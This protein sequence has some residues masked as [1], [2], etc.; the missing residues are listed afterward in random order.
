MAIMATDTVKKNKVALAIC[1]SL[2]S[3][4]SVAAEWQ[5]T[6]SIFVDE[7]YTDNVR[8]TRNDEKSSLVSQVGL[9]IESSYL[10]R[11]VQFDFKSAS[12]YAFYSHDHDIDDDYQDV[13]SNITAKLGESGFALIGN[14][15]IDNQSSDGSRNALADL[16]SGDTVQV[17]TYSSGIAY[18][19]SNS[20]FDFNSNLIYSTTNTEDKI[21]EQ[22][23]YSATVQSQNGG[24]ADYVFWDLQSGYQERKNR[25][26]SSRQ[27]QAE[28]K[29]GLITRWKINPFIRYYDEDNSGSISSGRTNESNSYGVGLRW[30]VSPRLFLDVSYNKPIGTSIDIDGKTQKEY[31]DAEIN[32]QPSSRTSVQAGY[33]QRFYG[34]S[35]NLALTHRNRRLTNTISYNEQVLSFTRNNFNPVDQGAFWCPQGDTSDLTACYL[36]SN[37][38]IDFSGFQLVRVTDFELIEDAVLSL[39]KT[40]NWNSKLDLARTTFTLDLSSNERELL[41]TRSIDESKR[42]KFNIARKVSGRSS[43]DLDLSYT[44]NNY[45]QGT[46]NERKDRYRQVGIGYTKS[47]N[48]NL[49]FSFDLRHVNRSSTTDQY[50]YDEGRVALKITKDF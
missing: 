4:S 21:G 25:G 32:W 14:L 35:Y 36:G 2:V 29:L 49:D 1:V 39:N 22:D 12:T 15:R 23:G 19:V 38:D 27:Y 11:L 41:E 5:L 37:S 33:S 34:D 17:E 44:E 43:I 3:A 45:Q 30:L 42:A 47:L 10:S 31:V 7:T 8:V 28:L 20:Q 40:L 46:T 50:N 16:V 6:P 24:N 9:A 48:S 26:Q 18:T 13:E